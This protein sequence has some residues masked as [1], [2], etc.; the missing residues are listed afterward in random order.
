[1]SNKQ[2][3][4]FSCYDFFRQNLLNTFY[5]TFF[6][7]VYYYQRCLN[8]SF[9]LFHIIF[10]LLLIRL[11]FP[12]VGIYFSSWLQLVFLQLLFRN[13]ANQ[14]INIVN[15]INLFSK[16]NCILW[17]FAELRLKINPLTVH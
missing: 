9:I 2:N 8:P 4:N 17:A 7:C 1:M 13:N 15:I 12:K 11:Y 10:L 16:I 14:F 3:K 5:S 6:L